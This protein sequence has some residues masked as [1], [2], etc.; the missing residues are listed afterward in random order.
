[1]FAI[2]RDALI[3]DIFQGAATA[4]NLEYVAGLPAVVQ[5]GRSPVPL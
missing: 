4:R 1:M 3:E 5:P 2:D